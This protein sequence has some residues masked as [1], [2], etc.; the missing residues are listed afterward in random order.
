MSFLDGVPRIAPVQGSLITRTRVTMKMS[1]YW[2][3]FRGLPPFAAAA[4]AAAAA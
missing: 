4:A 3:K 1:G 2:K